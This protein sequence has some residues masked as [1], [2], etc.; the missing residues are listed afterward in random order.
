MNSLKNWQKAK[1]LSV[2]L[3]IKNFDELI[4]SIP[5]LEFEKIK[6]IEYRIKIFTPA[7]Q[8]QRTAGSFFIKIK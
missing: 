8:L 2:N 3:N 4:C 7:A 1:S 6:K 5:K